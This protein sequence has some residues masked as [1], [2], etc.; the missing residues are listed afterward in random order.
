MTS[1]ECGLEVF[2]TGKGYNMSAHLAGRKHQAA[3]A[4]KQAS[5]AVEQKVVEQKVDQVVE[6]DDL[7]F[8]K[9]EEL[10]T[11]QSQIVEAQKLLESIRIQKEELAKKIISD[12]ELRA[13]LLYNDQSKQ[14][15]AMVARARGLVAEELHYVEAL[16]KEKREW[17]TLGRFEKALVETR[18]S[19]TTARSFNDKVLKDL[20]A[21]SLMLELLTTTDRFEREF[22]GVV[23]TSEIDAMYDS[24]LRLYDLVRPSKSQ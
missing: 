21:I 17:E 18:N 23:Q 7:L 19:L 20:K 9:N 4:K 10:K 1:C 15:D 24:T 22:R 12:A 8:Q 5:Q 2:D 14:V 13:K 3:M 11:L 6:F 16:R